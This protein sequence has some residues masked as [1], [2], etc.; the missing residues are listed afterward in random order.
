MTGAKP[1]IF[2]IDVPIRLS[3]LILRGKWLQLEEVST[4]RVKHV[5]DRLS[6]CS[7]AVYLHF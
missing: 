6:T 7:A 4:Y 5:N 3:E 2:G 1:P